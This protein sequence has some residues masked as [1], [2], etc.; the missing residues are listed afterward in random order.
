MDL[1][2]YYQ[3]KLELYTRMEEITALELEATE[4]ADWDQ[5]S[6]L[7]VAGGLIQDQVE[8]LD[9]IFSSKE[10]DKTSDRIISEVKEKIVTIGKEILS[11]HKKLL[12]ALIK[13][14]GE[15]S[16]KVGHLNSG[17]RAFR[18]YM[19]KSLPPPRFIDKVR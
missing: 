14:R 4:K 18:N 6:R 9:E 3:E 12:P 10:N 16:R 17:K 8:H 11:M 5:L 1:Q 7:L 2:N 19:R 13:K 15:L